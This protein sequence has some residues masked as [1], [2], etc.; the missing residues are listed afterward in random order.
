MHTSEAN[1]IRECLAL[2][3]LMKPREVRF[4]KPRTAQMFFAASAAKF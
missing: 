4:K 3:C 1:N 2:N